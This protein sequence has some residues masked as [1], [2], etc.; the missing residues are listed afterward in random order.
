MGA[1]VLF[2]EI[3]S[4][5]LLGSTDNL[6]WD[7]TKNF[8]S[9]HVK[10]GENPLLPSPKGN[11]GGTLNCLRVQSHGLLECET[12]PS[13]AY[14]SYPSKDC[15]YVP[16]ALLFLNPFFVY[17]RNRFGLVYRRKGEGQFSPQLVVPTVYS[18]KGFG[19]PSKRECGFEGDVKKGAK[20]VKGEQRT[21][22]GFDPDLNILI[23]L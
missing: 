20:G 13:A 11:L 15:M 12:L 21:E 18:N 14:Y 7:S 9:M 8:N 1:Q 10:D 22:S 4:S 16:F 2:Q 23:F 17:D 5:I 19:V 3:Q 6:V